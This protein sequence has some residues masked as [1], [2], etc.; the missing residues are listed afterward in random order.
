[1]TAHE[2]KGENDMKKC[3]SIILIL[4]LLLFCFPAGAEGTASD[5]TGDWYGNLGGVPMK[6]T[7]SEDGTCAVSIPGYEPETGI[8]EEQ[9]GTIF[10]NGSETPEYRLIG[11]NLFVYGLREFFCREP[12]DAYS[13]AA[14]TAE[15]PTEAW[16]GYWVCAYMDVD[17]TAYPASL[18]NDKT[19]LYVEGTSAIL[20][21]PVLCDIQVKMESVDGALV[22]AAEGITVTLRMQQ[23][24]FLR[25]TLTVDEE[26]LVWYLLPA[27]LAV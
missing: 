4:V 18:L 15:I 5:V 14:L 17:G 20:G 13:P 6:I 1:M 19:D 27:D 24:G 22:C 25:M 12:Q 23:D 11:N 7:L 8:W 21:G 26:A 10:L 3:T 2:Q 9:D 16:R